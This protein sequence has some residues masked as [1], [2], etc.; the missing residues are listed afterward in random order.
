MST[1]FLF[2]RKL[3][4]IR[5]GHCPCLLTYSFKFLRSL[6]FLVNYM[7]IIEYN[8]IYKK[9]YRKQNFSICQ[10]VLPPVNFNFVPFVQ[11]IS[12]QKTSIYNLIFLF[13]LH[14]L[15]TYF[16]LLIMIC[17]FFFCNLLIIV[18]T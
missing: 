7:N 12:Q 15:L 16:L 6:P 1:I 9:I 4:K 8:K 2:L 14:I 17:V 3:K 5:N 11:K 13:Y 10:L 18:S